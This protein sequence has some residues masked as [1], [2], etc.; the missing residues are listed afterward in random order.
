MKRLRQIFTNVS[1]FTKITV[2][3]I[4]IT[5]L[6]ITATSL[7]IINTLSNTIEKKE[8]LLDSVAMTEITSYT[9]EKYNRVY[10]LLN[11]LESSNNIAD[12]LAKIKIRPETAYQ[13]DTIKFISNG[14]SA[15]LASD[16]DF[17]DTILI[18][19]NGMVYSN[20]KDTS[21]T[22]MVSYNYLSQN[23]IKEFL[24]SDQTITEISDNPNYVND[25]ARQPVISFLAKI[26]DPSKYPKRS[27]V[28]VCIF[29][30][31]VNSFQHKFLDYSSQLK[32][33]IT[34][35]NSSNQILFSFNE[36]NWGQQYSQH[37]LQDSGD[38]TVDSKEVGLSGMT[39][40]NVV[41]PK[42]L[43]SELK[44]I[45]NNLLVLILLILIFNIIITMLIFRLFNNK[46]QTLI[47][48]M[49]KVQNG[50]LNSRIP[51]KTHDEIGKLG[52]SFNQMCDKLE[53]Y[54]NRVYYAEINQKNAELNMLQAQI[55]PHFLFNTLETIRMK[56]H[57][58]GNEE[59]ASMTALLGSLFRWNVKSSDKIISIAEELDYIKTYLEIQQFRR[60]S[61]F[62][63]EIN[64]PDDILYLGIPKLILQPLVENVFSHGFESKLRDCNIIISG[65][66]CNG[67]VELLIADNGVGID[68]QTLHQLEIKKNLSPKDL[69]HSQIGIV[70]VH[71]RLRLIFGDCYGVEIES[72]ESVGTTVKI[73][74]PAMSVKEMKKLCGEL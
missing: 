52:I 56:A 11:H 4:F 29:N 24:K 59:L 67:T 42:I 2:A 51:I 9:Q 35:V 26:Y 14:L 74:L 58:D 64:V 44:A 18:T 69:N 45:Q 16:S 73:E 37:L 15:M 47:H 55:N 21:R 40:Y 43:Q 1:L 53:E 49:E 12:L 3:F 65:M 27:V 68:K 22:I 19:Q 61:E 5:I 33:D 20:T 50:R 46:I 57:N 34:L 39:V 54:I 66:L 10:D 25:N 31:A 70:N 17:M 72:R 71:Q 28:G 63:F 62:E 30:I 48:Y 23:K 13:Y 6:S 38:S 36:N 8:I 60:S 32:G 7:I 41:S